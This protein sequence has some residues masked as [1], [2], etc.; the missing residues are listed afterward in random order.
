[1]RHWNSQTTEIARM[2]SE[3]SQMKGIQWSRVTWYSWWLS[4]FFFLIIVPLLSF[5]IGMEYQKTR[6]VIAAAPDPIES[7]LPL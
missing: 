1:M 7:F 6:D 4:V 5:Y 3:G 2:I